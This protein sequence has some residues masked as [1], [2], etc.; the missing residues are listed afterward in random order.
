MAFSWT[1]VTAG[2]T[3]EIPTHLNE[4]KT[5]TD[6]IISNLGATA[7]TWTEMPV[8][9]D[10]FAK[11]VQVQECQDALDYADSVNICSAENTSYDGTV[12]SGDDVTV[13]A[14]Q[15]SA[16]DASQDTAVDGARNLTVDND[17]HATY[18]ATQNNS[19]LSDQNTTVDS[20]QH[21]T[22]FANRDSSYLND[23]NSTVYVDRHGTYDVDQNTTIY[24]DYNSTVYSNRNASVK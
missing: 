24:V 23:Q 4:V 20:D 14:T 12:D 11:Q 15:Y 1:T 5:N 10:D 2:V 8:V 21:N 18:D 3:I 22:Y 17:Q 19:I 9:S 16:V 7:Y 6:T 13:Y